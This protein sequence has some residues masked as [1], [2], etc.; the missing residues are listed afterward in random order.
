MIFE[1]E[2]YIHKKEVDWSAL[3]LGINIPVSVQIDFHNQI[4][5]NLTKGDTIDIKIIIHGEFY[6]AKLTN[7]N[8]DKRKYPTHK[9][10]VQ[11]RYTPN[12]PISKKLKSIFKTSYDYLRIEKEKLQ[13]KRQHIK[14]PDEIKEYLILYT[15]QFDNTFILESITSLELS[16]SNKIIS[17]IKEEDIEFDINYF[18]TDTNAG[19]SEKLQIVKIRK[20]D[21]SICTNLKLLYE[22]K[23]QICGQNIG[24]KYN[25]IV[26][27][28]HH[29]HSFSQSLNNDFSNIMIVCPNHHRIIHKENPEFNKTKLAYLYPNGLE[30][31]LLI[32]KHL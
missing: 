24:D 4:S 21:R 9:E 7:I 2:T 26:S 27:E 29:I 3:N 16:E 12:S 5:K 18:K 13:N 23:C 28:A 19:F 6:S 8:F 30:E 31:R 32:N 15:T 11:I 17:S 20:L 22:N 10:L 14:L 25:T 1:T